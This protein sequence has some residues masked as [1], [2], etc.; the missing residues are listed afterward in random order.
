MAVTT[1]R[2]FTAIVHWG[3]GATDT[4][5]VSGAANPFTYT[6]N[7]HFHGLNSSGQQRVSGQLREDVVYNNGASISCSSDV[8]PWSVTR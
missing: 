4:A 6:F 3:D 5:T 7:G 8:M 2:P 1:P